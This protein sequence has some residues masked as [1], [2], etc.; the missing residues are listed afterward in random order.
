MRIKRKTKATRR[1]PSESLSQEVVKS[2]EENK[3]KRKKRNKMVGRGRG[4]GQ[5][6]R[7]DEV[8]PPPPSRSSPHISHPNKKEFFIIA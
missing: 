3:T 7:L 2:I 8:T 4:K 6:E 1:D 5:P